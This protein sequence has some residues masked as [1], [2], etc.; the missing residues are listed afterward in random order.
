[1]KRIFS[2]G[3]IELGRRFRLDVWLF[4]WLIVLTGLCVLDLWISWN[5]FNAL[6]EADLI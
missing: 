1:M 6:L 4:V 3:L 5:I 2:I